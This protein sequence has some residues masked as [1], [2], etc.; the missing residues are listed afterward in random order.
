M[1]SSWSMEKS[2]EMKEKSARIANDVSMGPPWATA[3]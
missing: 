1:G 3:F 2:G